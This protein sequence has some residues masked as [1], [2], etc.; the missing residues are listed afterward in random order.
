M[1]G[2]KSKRIFPTIRA[3]IDDSALMKTFASAGV[4]LFMAPTAVSLEIEKQY[5]V[6]KIGDVHGVSEKFYAITVR[7]KIDHP[8]ITAVLECARDWLA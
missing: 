4:G 8:A 3:E 6:V 7:R 2:S 1:N 5:G